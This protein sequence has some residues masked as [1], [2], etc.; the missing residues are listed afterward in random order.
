MFLNPPS[1]EGHYLEN[2]VMVVKGYRGRI[3]E[4]MS[5]K[6]KNRLDDMHAG[7]VFASCS[8]S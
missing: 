7:K 4:F 2:E 3:S 8:R 1:E 5:M 6:L